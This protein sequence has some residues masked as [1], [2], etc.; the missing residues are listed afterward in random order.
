MSKTIAVTVTKLKTAK[1][2]L[3]KAQALFK[4]A[5][6]GQMGPD[7]VKEFAEEAEQVLEQAQDL[8]ETIIEE[9]PASEPTNEPRLEGALHE[10][11]RMLESQIEEEDDPEKRKILMS[12]LASM[13]VA[14]AKI[15]QEKDEEEKDK[16]AALHEDEKED[17]QNEKIAGL[18][19]ELADMKYKTAK[20]KIATEYASLFQGK[21]KTAKFQSIMKS[22]EDLSLLTAKLDEAKS[23]LGSSK[24][25]IASTNDDW[26][27]PTIYS[28]QGKSSQRSASMEGSGLPTN[29]VN[30]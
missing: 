7:E 19:K 29:Y 24:V 22:K 8:V 21:Q 4:K 15:A 26:R 27:K 17:D 9:V 30:I 3:G 12:K 5:Q 13:K 20:E 28:E 10:D 1:D 16:D 25:K 14:N 6:E 23:L 2:S 11:E 18:T